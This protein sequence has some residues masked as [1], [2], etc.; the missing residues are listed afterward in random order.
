MLCWIMLASTG[1][2]HHARS[3]F[4]IPMLDMHSL[5]GFNNSYASV[6]FGMKLDHRSLGNSVQL[7][8]KSPPEGRLDRDLEEIFESVSLFAVG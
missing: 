5:R 3:M 2:Y 6:N 4:H 8:P 1:Q 7:I